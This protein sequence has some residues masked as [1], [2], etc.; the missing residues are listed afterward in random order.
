MPT[1][2]AICHLSQGVNHLVQWCSVPYCGR[3]FVRLETLEIPSA[4]SLDTLCHPHLPVA[5][6][7]KTVKQEPHAI[8]K[9]TNPVLTLTTDDVINQSSEPVPYLSSSKN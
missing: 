8:G 2:L 3:H 5:M 4:N 1:D 6:V 9:C 7:N